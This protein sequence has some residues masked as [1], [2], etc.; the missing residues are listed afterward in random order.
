MQVFG[1]YGYVA[2]FAIE[3]T[4]RD[5]RIAM[6]YE[7]SNE[8]QANDLLLRKVLGDGGQGFALLLEQLRDEA[9]H[10]AQVPECVGFARSLADLA[11]AL[12]ALVAQV[13]QWALE[14]AEYPYRCLLYT[15]PSPRD[16]S[17]SRMPSSA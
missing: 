17:T 3:Q 8:I 1:G 9:G 16:L 7:G 2:E 5:S 14:D 11:E 13:Q 10:G 6:I 12:Q 15:S 4:L